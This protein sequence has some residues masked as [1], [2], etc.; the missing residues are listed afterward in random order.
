MKAKEGR[1]TE[2][3]GAATTCSMPLPVL[4]QQQE[5]LHLQRHRPHSHPWWWGR[6]DPHLPPGWK[7]SHQAPRTILLIYPVSLPLYKSRRLHATVVRKFLLS[8]RGRL[9]GYSI[10]GI[11]GLA[12][13]R[14]HMGAC[15]S[16]SQATTGVNPPGGPVAPLIFES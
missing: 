12:A 4:P 15:G 10:H 14:A 3:P 8:D 2:S 7:L 1:L 11:T 6:R 13:L 5:A 16:P 9:Q